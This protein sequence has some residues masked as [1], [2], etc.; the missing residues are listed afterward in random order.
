MDKIEGLEIVACDR[1]TQDLLDRARQPL[2]AHNRQHLGTEEP[3]WIVV[4]AETRN[5][6][7]VGSATAY[8]LSGWLNVHSLWVS[9]EHRK[10]G[11]GAT[12]LQMLEKTA[13]RKSA[14]GLRL[15]TASFHSGYNLY[16]QHGF[17]EDGRW[18]ITSTCGREFDEI[19]MSKR[20]NAYPR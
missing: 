14:N 12:L 20:F 16:C 5:N 18:I 10:R 6:Q 4:T 9:P 7:Q 13:K 1:P 17:A 2:D 11:I 19:Q 8:F 3:E 15:V